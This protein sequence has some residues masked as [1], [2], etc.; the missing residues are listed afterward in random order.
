MC[1]IFAFIKSHLQNT[2]T[3][4][5]KKDLSDGWLLGS[6][7]GPEH[8]AIRD[9]SCGMLGFHRLAING[10]DESSKQPM[11]KSGCILICNG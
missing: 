3:E 10:L 9:L 11:N 7:R 6:S 2:I 5:L 1:G 8:S 4:R